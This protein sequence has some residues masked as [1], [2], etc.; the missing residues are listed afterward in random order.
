VTVLVGWAKVATMIGSIMVDHGGSVVR[1]NAQ[2]TGT[3]Q[4]LIL[5]GLTACGKLNSLFKTAQAPR[6]LDQ[7]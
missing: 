5:V 1:Q 6:V 2:S 4:I 3:G 7:P